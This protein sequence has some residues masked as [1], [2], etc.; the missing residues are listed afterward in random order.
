MNDEI[1]FFNNYLKKNYYKTRDIEKYIAIYY[2]CSLIFHD[3][4]MTTTNYI[5]RH[6][7]KHNNI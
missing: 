2:T 6:I 7:I 4:E 3:D 5:Y 1:A